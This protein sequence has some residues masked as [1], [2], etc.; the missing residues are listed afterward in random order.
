MVFSVHVPPEHTH[1]LY[2]TGP[3]PWSVPCTCS[4][5]DWGLISPFFLYQTWGL[6]PLFFVRT[7]CLGC[8]LFNL[9]SAGCVYVAFVNLTSIGLIT[10]SELLHCCQNSLFGLLRRCP[11]YLFSTV[12]IV[13][14]RVGQMLDMN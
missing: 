12:S 14:V 13:T 10:K 9:G 2:C 6:F 3:R 5:V 7:L 1:L 8:V 4:I 11:P